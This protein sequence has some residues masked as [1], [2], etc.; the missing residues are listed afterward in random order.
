MLVAL[1]RE[2]DMAERCRGSQEGL[3]VNV[4][5]TG[6]AGYVGSVCCEVLLDHGHK[7]IAV[8]NLLAAC[9]GKRPPNCVNPE[10]SQ[11]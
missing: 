10:V 3:R 1:F 8:D 4:L 5:V 9:A 7:L 6:A 2:D 11:H